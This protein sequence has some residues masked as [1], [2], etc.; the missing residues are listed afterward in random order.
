MTLSPEQIGLWIGFAFT[1]MVFSY[2]LGDNFL[3]RLAIFVFAGLAAGFI[4]VVTV[5]SIVLPWVN[6]TILAA[7]APPGNRFLG[8]LP[9]LFAVLLLL[10]T[11]PRLGRLGNLAVGFLV[12]VGAAVALVGAITGTL[13][14][15]T[16][17]T[18]ADLRADLGNGFLTVLGVVSTLIYFRFLGRRIPGTGTGTEASGEIRRGLFTRVFGGVGQAFIAVTFGAVYGGAILTGLTILSERIAFVITRI[19][20]I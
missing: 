17:A 2:V 16:N 8:L 5:E 1:L 20:G 10:K 13:I 6:S 12:G 9:V 3:Y 18:N 19:G 14:P 4:T 15:L 7:N 11:S